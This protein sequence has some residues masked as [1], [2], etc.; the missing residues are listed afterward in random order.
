MSV[1]GKCCVR[2]DLAQKVFKGTSVDVQT[3]GAKDSGVEIISSGTRHRGAAV[4]TEDF[5]HSYVRKKVETL[6]T[7]AVRFRTWKAGVIAI[8]TP[9]DKSIEPNTHRLECVASSRVINIPHLL[10]QRK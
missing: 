6:S 3:E 5:K 4:G 1:G 9:L 2:V 10:V 8:H 7:I